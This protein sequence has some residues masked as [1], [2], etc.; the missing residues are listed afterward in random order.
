MTTEVWAVIVSD[1]DGRLNELIIYASR[2]LAIKRV[3]FMIRSL[4]DDNPFRFEVK[5]KSVI[6]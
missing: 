6:G 2:E 1:Q 3:A 5:R 4:G